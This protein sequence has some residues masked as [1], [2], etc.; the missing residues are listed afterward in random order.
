MTTSLSPA[1][2]ANKRV[3]L[4]ICD[5]HRNDFVRDDTCPRIAD[6]A[7]RSRRFANHTAIFPSATR[8]SAASIATGCWPANHGLHGNSMGLPDGDGF[9]VHDVGD[10]AFVGKLRNAFGRTL[11]VP[12]MAERLAP[13]GGAIIA[14]NVSPGAAYFHDPDYFGHVV[15]RAGSFGPGGRVLGLDEAPV[16]SHDYAGDEALADWFCDDVLSVRKPRLSV[17]WLAN[18]DSAMHADQLGSQ[19]HLDGIACADRAFGHVEDTVERLRAEG[20]DILFLLGSDHGQETVFARVA[21]AARLIDAGLKDSDDSTDV[22]VAPQGGSGL[23]Y[24]ADAA[25]DRI[26]AILNFL[27]AQPWAA[28]I[29][30]GDEMLQLGQRPGNGLTIALA[31]ARNNEPNAL[32]VPGQITLCVSDD[33]PGKPEGYGSHGGLGA[34]ERHPFLVANGGGFAPG[35]VEHGVTRLID[36]AP[37]VMRFLGLPRDGMDGLALPQN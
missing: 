30:Y 19:T 22:V 5:G 21:V 33:K 17:L 29:F 34:Y 6:F 31:M 23:I 10:P 14:S 3:V 9:R 11:K 32:G 13:Y 36:I 4:M 24:V 28:E 7:A 20:E 15:H 8:A 18:P 37:T 16:V 2:E 35:T 27:R 25:K 12:T 1:P 26:P